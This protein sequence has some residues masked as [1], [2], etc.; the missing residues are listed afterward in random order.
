[1]G[2]VKGQRG[3]SRGLASPFHFPFPSHFPV[4]F[5]F[6]YLF[7]YPF[8]H[9]SQPL[10]RPALVLADFWRTRD[11]VPAGVRFHAPPWH[12]TREVTPVTS[13]SSML[14]DSRVLLVALD[15]HPV[16]NAV[17]TQHPMPFDVE[18]QR[19]QDDRDLVSMRQSHC[20]AFC[21]TI[22]SGP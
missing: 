9:L 8:P 12:V 20:S 15:K 10:L 6:P 16:R 13:V 2:E 21:C 4:H 14:Q 1:M 3:G 5:P 7:P 18:T 17:E 22:R 19:A 11:G